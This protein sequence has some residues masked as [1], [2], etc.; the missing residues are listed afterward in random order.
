[1][2]EHAVFLRR[3]RRLAGLLCLAYLVA[4]C[5]A[6]EERQVTYA[7]WRQA[8]PLPQSQVQPVPVSHTVTFAPLSQRLTDIEREALLRFLVQSKVQAGDTVMLTVVPPKPGQPDQTAARVTVLRS[9]LARLGVSAG[10]EFAS[11]PGVSANEILVTAQILTVMAPDCPGYNTPIALDFEQRPFLNL[12]CAN[13]TNLGLMVA[14]PAD[15][16]KGRPLPPADGEAAALSIQRY[17]AGKITPIETETT[18]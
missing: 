4:G 1:M 8:N 9:V 13:A 16:E 18:Q 2:S 14:D 3:T 6:T 15:L 11:I 7:T 10:A 17:R 5:T 12:G